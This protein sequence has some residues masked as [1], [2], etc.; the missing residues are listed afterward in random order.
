MSVALLTALSKVVE[1]SDDLESFLH[2][3]IY[4]AVR[5]LKSN[6]VDVPNW[7]EQYFDLYILSGSDYICG[8]IK[9]NSIKHGVLTTEDSRIS[10]AFHSPLDTLLHNLIRSFE[11]HYLVKE[12]DEYNA[13]Q[14][15]LESETSGQR[16][17]TPEPPTPAPQS[18]DVHSTP[19]VSGDDFDDLPAL[20]DVPTVAGEE[21][22]REPTTLQRQLATNVTHH[23][24]VL[25]LLHAACSLDGW[26]RV[27]DRAEDR[28][29]PGWQ[30]MHMQGSTFQTIAQSRASNR[31][32][33]TA[34]FMAVLD[35]P[36]TAGADISKTGT[37]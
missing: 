21:G 15:A 8:A 19:L 36:D 3:I 33:K 12:Y 13:M 27:E 9:A 14:A 28:V 30:S 32:Q 16:P 18:T 22:P 26:A 35:K 5:Y 24:A 25:T 10:L 20:R 17:P 31:R 34:H 11:A 4:Y 7:L 1:L 23:D 29:P 37:V 6:V 2:V